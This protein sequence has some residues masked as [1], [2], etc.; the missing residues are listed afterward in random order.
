MVL[1][2]YRH[3]SVSISNGSFLWPQTFLPRGFLV[4]DLSMRSCLWI[5]SLI[6]T[7]LYTPTGF[8]PGQKNRELDLNY[9]SMVLS[10][11]CPFLT[12]FPP[13]KKNRKPL[14]IT[15]FHNK[16][17]SDHMNVKSITHF[18]FYQTH[19]MVRNN[20][21]LCFV[22]FFNLRKKKNGKKESILCFN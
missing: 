1:F 5:F 21:F 14:K 13:P 17:R 4:T 7:P 3:F 16:S 19:I 8:W 12:S 15:Q 6:Q 22:I 20:L 11:S 10:C 2:Q 18:F 9:I